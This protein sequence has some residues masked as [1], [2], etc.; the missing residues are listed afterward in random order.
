MSKMMYGMVDTSG[1]PSI[2]REL[3]LT[4]VSYR[5]EERMKDIEDDVLRFD[6]PKEL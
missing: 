2:V 4:E 5:Y 3:K 6:F 1:K